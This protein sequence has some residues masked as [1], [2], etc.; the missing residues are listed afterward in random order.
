MPW[1]KP[2]RRDP[3]STADGEWSSCWVGR[4]CC[5]LPSKNSSVR[6][7]T[8]LS[9][10]DVPSR[11]FADLPDGLTAVDADWVRPA[12]YGQ[13]CRDAV[14]GRDGLA[15]ILW[16]HQPH[17][18]AVTVEIDP[19]LSEAT[20][21]VRLW[22]SSS[23]DPRDRA[24]VSRKPRAGS[25]CEVYLGS[26]FDGAGRTWLTHEQISQGALEALR[27]DHREHT[28]GEVFLEGQSPRGVGSP[29]VLRQ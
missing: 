2:P 10:R 5:D 22:G 26:T 17:R 6:A 7:S 14:A 23:G 21:V 24:R 16:V 29:S 18:D 12:E 8:S 28:V 27:G 13:R 9:W 25:L 1:E 4:E 11:A 15:V 20:R 3:G 19:L